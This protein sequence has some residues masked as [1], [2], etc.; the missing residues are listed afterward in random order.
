MSSTADTATITTCANCSKAE[1]DDIKLS[2]CTACKM[3][4]YCCREC[5]VAHRPQHKKACKKRAAELFDEELFKD[6][7]DSEECP[8]CMLRLPIDRS[9]SELQ[10]CCGNLLCMGCLHAQIKE[11]VKKGKRWDDV[12]LCAFCRAPHAKTE[13]EI[14][15]NLHKFTE[16]NHACVINLV[17]TYHINGKFGFPRDLNKAMEW[18]QKAGELGTAGAYLSLGNIFNMGYGVDQ[19]PKKARHYWELGA[20]GGNVDARRNL[21]CLDWNDGHHE[22]A[23]KHFTIGAKAGDENCLKEL[24]KCF[25]GGFVTKDEYTEVLR[26]YQK[27]QEDRKSAMRDEAMVYK[28]NP[29]LYKQLR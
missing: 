19:D 7:P 6:H 13:Q 17:A 3:V 9:H 8:I 23:S 21:A 10:V 28:A 20:I 1:A 14:V 26:A 15:N 22:R 12:G 5:Q 4:K 11:D 2:R 25:E 24:R 16:K 18:F 27:Q 29:Q